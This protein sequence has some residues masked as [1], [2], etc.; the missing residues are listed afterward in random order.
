[1]VVWGLLGMPGDLALPLLLPEQASEAA[2]AAPLLEVAAAALRHAPLVLLV[3]L[4]LYAV[5]AGEA[6][7]QE[8]CSKVLGF[9][10]S[11]GPKDRSNQDLQFCTEHHRRTCCERNHTR[12]VLTSFSAFSHERSGRCAQMSRL[13]LCSTCDADVGIGMKTQHNVVVLCPSFCA[14]WFKSC[15]DDY[16]APGGSGAKVQPCGPGSLVCSPLSEITKDPAVF[17]TGVGGF[18]VSE[19]EHDLDGCYDGVPAAKTR[20]RGPKAP[21]IKPSAARKPWWKRLLSGQVELPYQVQLAIQTYMPG[22]V[23]AC[24]IMFFSWYLWRGGD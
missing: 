14:R 3:V 24:V 2:A 15:E 7:P 1:M 19:S 22:V 21:W 16:F 17:C 18:A 10:E 8:S 5:G 20:G 6:E 13:A 23:V 11:S 4:Q 9:N 12:Q